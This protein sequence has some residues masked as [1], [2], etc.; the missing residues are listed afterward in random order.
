MKV[1][2]KISL[3]PGEDDKRAIMQVTIK[4]KGMDTDKPEGARERLRYTYLVSS[5]IA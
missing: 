1:V 2:S 4:K 3:N 5:D